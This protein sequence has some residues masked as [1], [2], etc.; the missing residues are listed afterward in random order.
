MGYLHFVPSFLVAIK[1]IIQEIFHYFCNNL[2]KCIYY[3]YFVRTTKR[4]S[5]SHQEQKCIHEMV[6]LQSPVVYHLQMPWPM[7]KLNKSFCRILHQESI[8]ST[9]SSINNYI[10]LDDLAKARSFHFYLIL[11][12]Q[13][14]SLVVRL[15][16]FSW[17][18]L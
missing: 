4:D 13:P 16:N 2:N 5:C 7:H 9:F 15:L 10:L 1:K 14:C 6:E 12:V 11:F 18:T 8:R 17:P 3:K